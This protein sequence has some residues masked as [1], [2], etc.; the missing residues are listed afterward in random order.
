MYRPGARNQADALTRREQD[1]D[2]LRS[3]KASLRMQVL[4]K[5]EQINLRIQL[6]LATDQAL[7]TLE[8]GAN[9]GLVDALLQANRTA[10]SLKDLR[11]E[12]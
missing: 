11:K 8:L 2:D 7:C 6:E 5:P 1:S 12:A 10:E 3:V 9:L 4:L